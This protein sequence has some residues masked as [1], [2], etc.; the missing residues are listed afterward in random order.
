MGYV[1][2]NGVIEATVSA[3]YLS[4]VIVQPLSY[5]NGNHVVYSEVVE[6]EIGNGYKIYK[7]TNSDDFRFRDTESYT[8]ELKEGNFFV[9]KYLSFNS[10]D[11]TRGLLKEELSYNE[12]KTPLQSITYDYNIMSPGSDDDNVIRSIQT[13][14]IKSEPPIGTVVAYGKFTFCPYLIMKTLLINDKNGNNPVTKITEFKY[15]NNNLLTDISEVQSDG[16]II[17]TQEPICIRVFIR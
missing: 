2:N 14:S 6:R 16:S 3:T 12:A 9:S 10:K 11:Y 17:I 13:R 4:D 5:T 15:N 1:T 7:F 8:F